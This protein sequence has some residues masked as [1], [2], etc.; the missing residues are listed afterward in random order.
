MQNYDSV[1]DLSH[2][3]EASENVLSVHFPLHRAC[4]DGDLDAVQNYLDTQNFQSF[5]FNGLRAVFDEDSFYGWTPIHYAAY[6]GRVNKLI[7]V[8]L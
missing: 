6:F 5:N 3:N 1:N 2:W 8:I 4:R 7:I